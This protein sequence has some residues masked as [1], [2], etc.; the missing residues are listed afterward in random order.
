MGA[1][2]L[3]GDR[4]LNFV[5]GMGVTTQYFVYIFILQN[6]VQYKSIKRQC[7]NEV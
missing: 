1:L 6:F 3:S 4:N 5:S 2:F 7:F